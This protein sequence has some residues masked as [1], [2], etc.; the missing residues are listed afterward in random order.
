M[1]VRVL[2]KDTFEI[3]SVF[4]GDSCCVESF[5]AELDKSFNSNV[6][7]L[8][9]MMEH[10]ATHGFNRLPSGWSHEIDKQE[11]IFELIKGRLR[12]PYFRGSGDRIVVCGPG[13]IKKSQKTPDSVKTNMKRLRDTYFK[14]L[15]SGKLEIEQ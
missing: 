7:D 14:S 6:A 13:F 12:I 9:S 1:K 2:I 8:L 4:V 15:D 11:K 3:A 10:M 5:F